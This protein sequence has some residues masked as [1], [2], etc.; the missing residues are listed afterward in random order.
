MKCN[1]IHGDSK[2]LARQIANYMFRLGS[3]RNRPCRRIQFK[4]GPLDNERGYG[5]LNKNALANLI[6]ERLEI[7]GRKTVAK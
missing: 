1:Q 5:G 7:Y 4:S 3:E 6:Q 2:R